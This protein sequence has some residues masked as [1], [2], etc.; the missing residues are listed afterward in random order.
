MTTGERTF[1]TQGRKV[2]TNT[3]T[4]I[5]AGTYGITFDATG[6]EI[7]KSDKRPDAVP[8]INVRFRVNGTATKEGGKDRVV[9]HRFLLGLKEGKDGVAN[10]DRESGIVAFSKAIKSEMEGVEIT[11]QQAT[12]AD[13]NEVTLEYLNP[14]QVVEYLKGFDGT[15][16]KGRIKV[17]K[18][19]EGY[20]DKNEVAKFLLAE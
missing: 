13:G 5:P 1:S 17:Q 15:E 16:L 10:V 7:A 3:N 20:S 6:I 18:G 8:Y 9:F 4:L 2:Q 11:T 14:K 19:T 12:D